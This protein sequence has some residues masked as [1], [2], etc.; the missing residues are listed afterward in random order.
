M[1]EAGHRGAAAGVDVRPAVR[2][3]DL[4]RLRRAPPR[5]GRRE[6]HD[7]GRATPRVRLPRVAAGPASLPRTRA[8]WRWGPLRRVFAVRIVPPLPRS[9]WPGSAAAARLLALPRTGPGRRFRRTT[10]QPDVHAGEAGRRRRPSSRRPSARRTTRRWAKSAQMISRKKLEDAI[11]APTRCAP[12][13]RGSRRRAS[14]RPWCRPSRGRRPPRSRVRRA[15]LGLPGD[16][17]TP[18]QPRRTSYA[19]QRDYDLAR[20]ALET[21][22][23][24]APDCA[25]ARENL[26][27]VYARLAAAQ[28]NRAATLDR[29]NHTAPEKL[30]LVRSRRAPKC[31]VA[32]PEFP[33]RH[34]V[35]P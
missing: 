25:V 24:T 29:S 7:A 23:R 34:R 11:A 27:D 8:R 9:A 16:A 31:S 18:Q 17:R 14:S 3:D 35:N 21:A 10:V 32:Q 26:G 15:G 19:Q 5:A 13:A 4:D 30:A 1:A 6:D 2:V 12:P 33:A 28:Y 22:V 20:D